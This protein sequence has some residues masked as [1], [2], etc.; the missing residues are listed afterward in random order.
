MSLCL[1]LLAAY[2]CYYQSGQTVLSSA[3]TINAT[4]I[5][6]A[7]AEYSMPIPI[8]MTLTYTSKSCLSEYSSTML[9]RD[10]ITFSA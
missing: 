7:G 3:P 9:M 10:Q 1:T 2:A 5:G 6:A 4:L 8:D